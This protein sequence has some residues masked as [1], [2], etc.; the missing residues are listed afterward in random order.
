[1]FAGND[2]GGKR[3]ANLYS[4]LGTAKLHGINPQAYMTHVLTHIADTKVN[5]V[6][7]LLPVECCL[8][9]DA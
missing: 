7:D 1:M 4:L 9:P 5:R 8:C 6:E 3:A 2:E